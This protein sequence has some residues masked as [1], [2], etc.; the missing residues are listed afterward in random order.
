[1]QTRSSLKNHARFHT[2]MAQK[3]YPIGRHKP[4][5]LIKKEYLPRGGGW[6]TSFPGLPWER[7]WGVVIAGLYDLLVIACIDHARDLL[8]LKNNSAERS[9]APPT[10]FSIY[11]FQIFSIRQLRISSD[12]FISLT[13]IRLQI[14]LFCISSDHGCL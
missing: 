12:H 14:S 10:R 6:S 9:A 13:F 11:Q 5:R 7:G 1:M 3:P 2:K 4:T 8:S